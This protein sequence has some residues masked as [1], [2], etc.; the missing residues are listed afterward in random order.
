[1]KQNGKDMKETQTTRLQINK[2][3]M[4]FLKVKTSQ[5]RDAMMT[6]DMFHLKGTSQQ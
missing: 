4:E 1:M 6:E 2:E 5:T 3:T